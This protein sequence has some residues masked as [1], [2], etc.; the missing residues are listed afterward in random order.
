MFGIGRLPPKS[1]PQ[2]IREIHE[3]F[4]KMRR[5]T[6][7]EFM[8]RLILLVRCVFAPVAFVLLV[9]ACRNSTASRSETPPPSTQLA[10]PAR[11]LPRGIRATGTVRAVLEHAIQAP[12]MQ[13]GQGMS[14]RMTLVRLVPNGAQVQKGDVLAEFDRTQQLDTAREALA[15]YE[16]LQ[17]QVEKQRAEN[18]SE[19]EKRA[20]EMA[21]AKAELAKAQIQ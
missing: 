15:K 18:R 19:T 3:H 5:L 2:R 11:Q 21:Q 4:L 1:A 12:R 20:E 9:T 7:T 6:L 14:G 16:D 8:A 17:H 13:G 10:T